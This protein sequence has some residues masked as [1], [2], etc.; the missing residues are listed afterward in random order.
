MNQSVI[1]SDTLTLAKQGIF[2]TAQ[3]QGQTITCYI[4]CDNLARLAGKL[5][6]AMEEIESLFEEYR[7]DI[8]EWAETLINNEAFNEQ[9]EI[10]LA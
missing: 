9:D 5:S 4:S 7:F 8:E 3:Q 10:H 2:F 1:F 6:I